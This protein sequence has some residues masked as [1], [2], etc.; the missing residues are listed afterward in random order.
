MATVIAPSRP[1]Q[2]LVKATI[3]ALSVAALSGIA[4][5]LGGDLSNTGWRVLATSAAFGIACTLAAAGA[6]LLR[7]PMPRVRAL[8]LASIALAGAGVGPAWPS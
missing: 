5:L 6:D 2:L 8:A 3:A 4:V 7:R 1:V